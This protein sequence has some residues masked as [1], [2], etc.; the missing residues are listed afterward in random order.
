MVEMVQQPLEEKNMLQQ[1]DR[2]EETEE[3]VE[4]FIL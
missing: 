3:K 4:V 2:M 1:V